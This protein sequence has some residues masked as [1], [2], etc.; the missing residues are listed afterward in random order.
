MSTGIPE[1]S[2]VRWASGWGLLSI[3]LAACTSPQ[4]PTG[5]DLPSTAK[6][7]PQQVHALSARDTRR[8]IEARSKI[9]FLHSLKT[10]GTHHGYIRVYDRNGDV[11]REMTRL[12]G[13]LVDRASTLPAEAAARPLSD[14]LPRLAN[15]QYDTTQSYTQTASYTVDDTVSNNDEL[16]TDAYS[17]S[18]DVDHEAEYVDYGQITGTIYYPSKADL[19]YISTATAI[20]AVAAIPPIFDD[21]DDCPGCDTTYVETVGYGDEMEPAIEQ[22]LSDTVGMGSLRAA[23]SKPA[24]AGD[25]LRL[26]VRPLSANMPR[27]ESRPFMT[28][29]AADCL[30]PSA[31]VT[32]NTMGRRRE[33]ALMLPT[34]CAGEYEDLVGAEYGVIAGSVVGIVAAFFSFGT[35]MAIAGTEAIGYGVALGRWKAG[36]RLHHGMADFRPWAHQGTNQSSI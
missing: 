21:G 6:Q 13:D 12:N 8:A 34:P 25:D 27:H 11:I 5:S 15:E 2:V 17:S 36:M 33:S 1:T 23:R 28:A 9:Y 22:V 7:S 19:G 30:A 10:G 29:L 4:T 20:L 16:D 18:Q 26:M 24:P 31:L 14:Y 3:A 35:S 32:S